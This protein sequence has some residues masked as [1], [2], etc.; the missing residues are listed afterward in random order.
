MPVQ[1]N[2]GGFFTEPKQTVNLARLQWIEASTA[3]LLGCCRTTSGTLIDPRQQ[4]VC[5]IVDQ[6]QKRMCGI[7]RLWHA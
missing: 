7:R 2:S 5:G 4:Q 1:T 3:L 6:I